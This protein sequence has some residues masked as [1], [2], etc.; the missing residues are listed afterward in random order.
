M[1][2]PELTPQAA[3]VAAILGGLATGVGTP[4]W[5]IPFATLGGLLALTWSVRG[6]PLSDAARGAVFGALAYAVGLRWMPG[7]VD[8]FVGTGG[9][10]SLGAASASAA[11]VWG[12]TMGISG[13][14]LSRDVD[15]PIALALPMCAGEAFALLLGPVPLGLTAGLATTPLLLGPAA[16][17]GRSLLMG[18]VGATASSVMRPLGLFLAVSWVALPL[19]ART[20]TTATTTVAIVQTNTSP[21]DERPSAYPAMADRVRF[22]GQADWVLTPEGAWPWAAGRTDQGRTAFATHFAD[23]PPT[24]LGVRATPEGAPANALALVQGGNVDHLVHKRNRIPVL[25]RKWLGFG[26]DRFPPGEGRTVRIGDVYIGTLICWEDLH[27]T[28]IADASMRSSVLALPSS[29][30]WLGPTGARQHLD[31]ARFAAVTSGRWVARATR[32]GHSGFLSPDGRLHDG[33]PWR[34]ATDRAEFRV[35]RIP[36]LAPWWSGA[37]MDPI[38]GGMALFLLMIALGRRRHP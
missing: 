35:R 12:V 11:L 33:I 6:E 2:R 16:I 26:T 31:A 14:A 24:L 7:A 15:R 10:V 18:W 28:S 8:A 23:M 29:D 22:D 36:L 21:L 25:E 20:P 5:P 13:F 30:V 4:A 19:A 17:G 27:P 1:A 32:N 3:W 38:V 37:A 9:W 34:T